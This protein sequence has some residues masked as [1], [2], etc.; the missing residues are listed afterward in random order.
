MPRQGVLRLEECR[1]SCREDSA[2]ISRIFALLL[3]PS[4]LSKLIITAIAHFSSVTDTRG[5]EKFVYHLS[6]V[7]L[8]GSFAFAVPNQFFCPSAPRM[9][10]SSNTTAA[11]I[12]LQKIIAQTNVMRCNQ[13]VQ[14][15]RHVLA[16]PIIFVNRKASSPALVHF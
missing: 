13:K 6:V 4:M 15:N 5:N 12:T 7:A 2:F 9:K 1:V 10:M 3:N 14:K 16:V 8:F 11:A